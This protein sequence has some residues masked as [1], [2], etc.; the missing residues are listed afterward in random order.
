MSKTLS[1]LFIVLL[2]AGCTMGN[3]DEPNNT[4]EPTTTE[5]TSNEETFN[6]V[7]TYIETSTESM[8][9]DWKRKSDKSFSKITL[10]EDGTCTFTYNRCDEMVTTEATFEIVGDQ[11]ILYNHDEYL[12][13]YSHP[14]N[15]VSF[16][17]LSSDE[18]YYNQNVGCVWGYDAFQKGYASFKKVI[19]IND[20]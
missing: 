3:I 5:P 15:E 6:I 4:T 1:S 8:P 2:L 12:S 18:I 16:T 7:G 14:D 20:N 19:D 9:D 11:I 10:N 17:I 13:D